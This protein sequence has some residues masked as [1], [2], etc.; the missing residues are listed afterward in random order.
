[1]AYLSLYRKYRSQTFDEL[2]GQ[3]HVSTTLSNAIV[4][5]RVAHAYLFTGPR[6]TGKT[7]TARIL[8][9]ALNCAKGPTPSPCGVCDACIAITEGSS[10]D[11][12]EM[13][14]ASHSKVDET[15]EI[16][17]GVPLAT[18]GGRK[19]VYVID[20][21]HML[22]TQAFNALLK[23]LEEPPSHVLFILATTEAHKVPETIRSRSQRFDFRRIPAEVIEKHLAHV[24]EL[25]GLEAEAPAL[26]AVARHAEGGMRDALSA[27]DQLSNIT[28]KITE[29]DAESLLGDRHEDQMSE[30]FDAISAG[31]VGSVFLGVNSLISQGADARQLA[32]GALGHA[33][34]LLLLLAAPDAGG[35]LDVAAED[36]PKLEAQATRFSP[37]TLLRVMDLA[38]KAVT[39]M[40]TAPNHRL[41]LEVALIRAAA[42]A[43]DPSASGLLGRI[44]RLERRIGIAEGSAPASSPQTAPG[45]PASTPAPAPATTTRSRPAA[46]AK[47]AAPAVTEAP[48]SV[49]DAPAPARKDAPKPAND[50]PQPAASDQNSAASQLAASQPATE[51]AP[52][53]AVPAGIGLA[54][55]KDA[56]SATITEVGSQS[57]RIQGLLNPSRPLSFDGTTLL[58]EVQAPYHQDEM[59]ADRN[60]AVLEEALYSA[61]G[62]RPALT[63]AARGVEPA[64]ADAT[65]GATSPEAAS[66]PAEEEIPDIEETTPVEDSEHDPIELVKRGLGGEVVEERTPS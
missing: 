18:A 7:S 32:L 45:A 8:A 13:D 19:K 30:L 47:A 21:V 60:R 49:K 12:I 28:G 41:L 34:S 22:S 2:L 5:D 35:L 51:E 11:V 24:A 3:D 33:R 40:R 31:D 37:E 50:T 6:G 39:E 17:H 27:L 16:L 25:E 36:V 55:I 64:A 4:E 10:M 20:E 29:A 59:T 38:G 62:I 26:A 48:K 58:V 43:T 9:K 52:A 23:T 61:L 53:P 14:A 44:E 63:F 56:W 15:R 65:A 57:K 1:M 66:T 42:P 46:A 54:H